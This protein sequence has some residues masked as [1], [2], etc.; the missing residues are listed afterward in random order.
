M[1]TCSCYLLPKPPMQQPRDALPCNHL[2]LPFLHT[3]IS[4]TNPCITPPVISPWFQKKPTPLAKKVSSRPQTT[5]D[6]WPSCTIS[7]LKSSVRYNLNPSGCPCPFYWIHIPV[8]S[9]P[10]KCISDLHLM[11]HPW[12]TCPHPTAAY[13]PTYPGFHYCFRWKLQHQPKL[14]VCSFPRYNFIWLCNIPTSELI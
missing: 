7:I 11:P 4:Y 9:W 5:P 10:H 13:L 2:P 6:T 1:L 12:S 3:F 8:T 14:C